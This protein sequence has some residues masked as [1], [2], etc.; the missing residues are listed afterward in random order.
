MSRI[1]DV[2]Q[3][4]GEPIYFASRFVAIYYYDNRPP[5]KVRERTPETDRFHKRCAGDAALRWSK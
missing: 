2:C 1:I 4:C 3:A 5:S